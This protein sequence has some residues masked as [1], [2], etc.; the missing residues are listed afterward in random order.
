MR[1]LRL[2]LLVAGVASVVYLVTRT[3]TAALLEPIRSLGWGLVPVLLAPYLGVTLLHTLA[4]QF[5]LPRDRVPFVTLGLVRLA[6]ETFNVATASVGGEPVKAL[7]L[8]PRVPLDRAAAS[9]VVDKTTIVV[10]QGLL[11]VVGLIV[12]RA[13]FDLPATFLQA[14]TW[15]LVVEIVAVG[16]F[17]L[18]QVS[19]VLGRGLG[20]LGRVGLGG[21]AR[22]A[23]PVLGVER[24]VAAFYREH[25]GG[26]A[27]SIVLHWL[28]WLVGSLEVYLILRLLDVESSLAAAVVIEA[29]A[30]AIRFVAFAVPG[31]LGALEAGTMVV[32]ATLG[33]GAELGLAVM[34]VRRLRQIAWVV[35]GLACLAALREPGRSVA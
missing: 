35:F 34:L 1:A 24:T 31:A 10:G 17:A 27:L 13:A 29:F 14:M 19:G 2:V 8:R 33:L 32:F 22:R 30:T 21:L 28:G 25:R 15:L 6:G 7:L 11:L 23:G 12:A 26:L 9:V 16:G 20:L 4:W 18:A 5:V 3:G